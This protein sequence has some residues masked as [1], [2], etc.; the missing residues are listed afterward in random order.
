MKQ[1]NMNLIFCIFL[2]FFTAC[3]K[4]EAVNRPPENVRL[5]AVTKS[6]DPFVVE[7]TANAVDVDGDAL[8]YDWNFGNG[9]QKKGNAVEA[10]TYEENKDYVIIVNISDGKSNPVEA[11]VGV[12]TKTATVT[13]DYNKKFQTISGFGAFGAQ[14]VPWTDG[15]FTSPAFIDMLVNDLGTTIV[16]DEVPTNFEYVNDNADPK[17]TDLSK[18]NISK[19]YPGTHRHLGTRLPFF[20]EMKAANPEVK[21]IASVWS[22]PAWMKHNNALTNGTKENS[23]PPYNKT[24]N[25]TS[26]QLKVEMYEEFAEMCVAYVRI[27]KRETGIDLYAFSIQN[28][29]RFSQSYQSCVYDG[30]AI[31]DVMKVVGKRFKDEGIQTLLFVPEDIG[32]LGGVEGMTKPTLDDPDARQYV[33]AVAVHGYDLDG[34]KPNSPSANTW[35]TM[36]NW[37]APYNIPLWMTETS[38]FKN[39]W[40]GAMDLA[41]AIYTAL[42]HGNVSAW[43]FWAMSEPTIT[44]Y[45]LVSSS[46]QKSKRYFTSKQFYKFIRPGTVRVEASSTDENVAVIAFKH[47]VTNKSTILLLNV[48]SSDKL[49]RVKGA[50]LPTQ[51]EAYRSSATEDCKTIGEFNSDKLLT[52]PA[53]SITTLYSK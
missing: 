33:G 32:W 3:K 40:N 41:E 9:M 50:G 53:N 1:V 6:T 20:K 36:Y 19:D 2:T 13:V 18:F 46:L 39:D 48:G 42:R 5:T 44:E 30:T 49:V 14:N 37:G 27:L 17:V 24:P 34:I 7:F 28:E 23:A 11:R 12:S 22:P 38:G 10:A 25:A 52:L 45:N 29:P 16:R 26:N 21:F 51:L 15:P 35:Q 31:R 43:V 8:K 4:E 47:P